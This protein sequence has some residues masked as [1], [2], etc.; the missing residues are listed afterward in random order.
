MRNPHWTVISMKM[1]EVCKRTGL[2]ER[3]VRFYVSE[4]LVTPESQYV[5][6]RTYIDFSAAD[7]QTLQAVAVLRNAQFT[8]AEISLMQQD[9]H[10]LETVPVQAAQ[11]LTQ[12]AETAEKTASLLS[13]ADGKG[14]DDIVSLAKLLSQGRAGSFEPK[15]NFGKLDGVSRQERDEA[16]ENFIAAEEKRTMKKR[17]LVLT[18]A[19]FLLVLVSVFCTL[20]LTGQLKKE[21]TA[22]VHETEFI[23]EYPLSQ[24]GSFEDKLS[25]YI[26]RP[27]EGFSFKTV[28]ESGIDGRI[29]TVYTDG[30]NEISLWGRRLNESEA[31]AAEEMEKELLKLAGNEASPENRLE[32]VIPGAADGEYYVLWIESDTVKETEM[33]AICA[34]G[35]NILTPWGEE[36]EILP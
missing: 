13:S 31:L 3:A 4:G 1:K 28:G 17:R 23:R 20:A 2:T 8:V 33:A 21:E 22:T 30:E 32:A 14:Y 12:M 16:F 9:R 11:R 19:A 36:I 34:G 29:V 25:G 5:R 10:A 24:L 18:L 6:G 15:P 27:S 7:V 35:V 26:P